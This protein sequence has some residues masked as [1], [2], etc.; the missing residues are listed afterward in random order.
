MVIRGPIFME[1]YVYRSDICPL[2]CTVVSTS[3]YLPVLLGQKLRQRERDLS[4]GKMMVI[5][6][7]EN[8]L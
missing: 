3:A 4:D 7:D 1:L 6:H 8:Q 5:L 2:E